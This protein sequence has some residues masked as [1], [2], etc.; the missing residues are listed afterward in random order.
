MIRGRLDRVDERDGVV[1]ILDLKT[2]RVE[3]NS[4]RIRE[5]SLDA[6]KGDKGHAAQLLVYAWLYLTLH[7]EVRE[8]RA[9]LQPLQRASGSAG[10]YLRVGD[11][12]LIKRSD[13]PAITDLLTEAV[14]T[15]LDPDTVFAHDPESPFCAF[16]AQAG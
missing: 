9:G 3:E 7:P 16:C 13:L 11:R 4:L 12:D 6:L 1:H 2:G 5:L 15:L 8:V 14:R 10:V